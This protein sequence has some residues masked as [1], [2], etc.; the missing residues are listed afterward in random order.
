MNSPAQS[1]GERATLSIEQFLWLRF[2]ISMMLTLTNYHNIIRDARLN[3]ESER[4][5]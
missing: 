2:F 1:S 3:A 5:P 4:V